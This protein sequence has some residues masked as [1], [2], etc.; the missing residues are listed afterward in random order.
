MVYKM[1]IVI[2]TLLITL[3]VVVIGAA[4]VLAG[5]IRGFKKSID[6]L[7]NTMELNSCDICG[8]KASINEKVEEYKVENKELK[9]HIKDSISNEVPKAIF[10]FLYPI[11]PYREK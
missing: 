4:V 5:E 7:S 9:E 6:N 10:K 11:I 2:I 3:I 8:I 1:N